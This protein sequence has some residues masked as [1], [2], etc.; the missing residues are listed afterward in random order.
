MC[1]E[2]GILLYTVLFIS[3]M[4]LVSPL[5]LPLSTVDMFT[6]NSNPNFSSVSQWLESKLTK[7]MESQKS[8]TKG[9]TQERKK[10]KN[11]KRQQQLIHGMCDAHPLILA[12]RIRSCWYVA[13]H[14]IPYTVHCIASVHHTLNKLIY[15]CYE[16]IMTCNLPVRSM[17]ACLPAC[18]S[19]FC[20]GMIH[21]GNSALFMTLLNDE[22]NGNVLSKRGI[23]RYTFTT[24]EH[25]VRPFQCFFF[26]ILFHFDKQIIISVIII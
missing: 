24:R 7:R 23:R 9:D 25:F 2:H 20:A 18:L 15:M 26:V 22:M 19:R 16:I 8:N 10:E 4:K 12:K 1:R 21:K 17:H 14:H 3:C 13:G 6:V 11:T 5:L